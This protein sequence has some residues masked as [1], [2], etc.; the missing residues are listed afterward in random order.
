MCL[1]GRH[2]LM[3]G[4]VSSDVNLLVFPNFYFCINN[5]I[6]RLHLSRNNLATFISGQR[7]GFELVQH[8][9]PEGSLIPSAE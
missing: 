5:D 4:Y 9:R 3:S 1:L 7:G 6:A 8:R 2:N